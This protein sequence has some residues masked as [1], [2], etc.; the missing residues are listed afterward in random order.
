MTAPRIAEIEDIFV[1]D[2]ESPTG[3]MRVGFYTHYVNSRYSC[4]EARYDQRKVRFF[5]PNG[6]VHEVEIDSRIE[7]LDIYHSQYGIAVSDEH[8]CFFISSWLKGVY[9][10]DLQTG[11]IRWN[12]RLKH[13]NEVVVYPDFVLGVFQEIGLRK[14]S[15]A[16]E[17]IAKYPSTTYN[18]FDSLEDPYVFIGPNRDAYLIVDV[19]TMQLV[20]RIRKSSFTKPD[21]ELI[22]LNAKGN[23]EQIRISGFK[24]GER[25]GQTINIQ[26]LN[27]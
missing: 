2:S 3:Q 10:C 4:S 1:E 24:N 16:G 7:P 11:K 27:G 14:L 9:C 8:D 22:I 26:Q 23:L 13:G 6:S 18:V 15:Y 5:D 17:E 20:R 21:D 19:S 25:F 12:Y